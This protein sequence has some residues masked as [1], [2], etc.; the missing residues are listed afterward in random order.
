MRKLLFLFCLLGTLFMAIPIG[1]AADNLSEQELLQLLP[2][3]K[4]TDQLTRGEY[5]VMLSEAVGFSMPTLTKL[6]IDVAE[7]AWY[8]KGIQSLIK[9]NVMVGYVDGTFKP[10]QP[11]K[12]VEAVVILSRVLGLPVLPAQDVKIDGLQHFP[13]AVGSYTWCV[14]EGFLSATADPA[15]VITRQEGSKLLVGA[16]STDEEGREIN[17]KS[18]EARNRVKT[19]RMNGTMDMSMTLTPDATKEFP[20]EIANGMSFKV[21]INTE[22]N[23]EQ[24]LHQVLKMKM[25]AVKTMQLPEMTMEQYYTAEGM[26]MQMTDPTTGESKWV[27]YPDNIL[28]SFETII[29]QGTMV[30]KEMQQ[31]FHY[32]VLDEK[33]ID[34]KEYLQ[35]A[36]YGRINDFSQLMKLM[37]ESIPQIDQIAQI[38]NFIDSMSFMGTSLINKKTYLPLSVT[39]QAVVGFK[40]PKDQQL[41][42]NAMRYNYLINYSDYQD[43][44]VIQVPEEALT[45]EILS[46]Q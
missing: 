46:L 30:N 39:T 40:A 19:M 6:P 25:P 2:N 29:N 42:F 22:M 5:A 35:V 8:A 12:R 14:K 43:D 27:K 9:N 15:G 21:D 45:A 1:C 7:G 34:E 10:D 38:E 20:A 3:D 18:E 41:P 31:L 33:V 16:F 44:I 4:E 26:F 24:G 11:I 23:T 17:A 13:W 36:Y 32:R 37:G 28:P